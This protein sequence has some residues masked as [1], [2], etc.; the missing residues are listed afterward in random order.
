MLHAITGMVRGMLRGIIGMLRAITG[1]MLLRQCMSGMWHGRRRWIT[2]VLSLWC[3][4]ICSF[5]QPI[6]MQHMM[7]M[8][9]MRFLQILRISPAIAPVST[10]KWRG[11][12]RGRK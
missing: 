6:L 8:Q 11:S 4:I 9:H 7:L 1:I 3:C 12:R 5:M 10:E 2:E